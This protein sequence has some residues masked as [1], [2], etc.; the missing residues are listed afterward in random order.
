[1]GAARV[2]CGSDEFARTGPF[3]LMRVT[4]R[5]W[6]EE[7]MRT[8]PALAD[9][10]FLAGA[11]DM[12]LSEASFL[13]DPDATVHG[14]V[15]VEW[16][17]QGAALLM[18]MG[19]AATPTATWII[20]RDDSEPGYHVLY[21]DDRGVSRACRMSSSDGTWRMWRDTPGFCQRFG[22]EVAPGQAEINGSWQKP[23][24]AGTTWEHDFKVRYRR[25]A[26]P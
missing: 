21:A 8:N 13:P 3:D 1:M 20:G 4:E 14:S 15:T 12:E 22:A 11:W 23:V 19:D 6:M 18:H 9:V 5:G 25:R 24:D 16:I 10:Q 26:V 17:E 2:A 7:A